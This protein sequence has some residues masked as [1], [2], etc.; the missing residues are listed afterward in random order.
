VEVW[1][2]LVF[3]DD[4]EQTDPPRA[5]LRRLLAVGAVIVPEAAV[6]GY[7]ADLAAIRTDLDVP[8]GDELKW[9][10]SRG[11][12]L[13]SAGGEINRTL[14]TRMLEAAIAQQ[15]RTVVVIRDFGVSRIKEE[16]GHELL[17]YLYERISMHL[18]AHDDLGIVIADK[19]GGGAREDGRWLAETLPLTDGG[20][21]YIAADR[22]VLP[23]VTAP[24]HHV[25]H[26]QLADLVVAATT[27]AVA[28]L[29]HGMELAP[30]L[31]ELMVTSWYGN[32]GGSGIVLRPNALVNLYHWVFGEPHYMRNSIGV[33]LPI[34]GLPYDT[35]KGLSTALPA[36]GTGG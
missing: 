14:R 12:F 7:A 4:S 3:L 36:G 31:R 1:V 32:R 29:P 27:A 28:G 8:P 35:D 11:S 25:P 5:G 24:S 18:D 15:V 6:A 17:R 16:V 19:P 20:T 33:P 34:A 2:R 13:A 9:K 30:L 26:L 21:E 10:P 22:I 23:I